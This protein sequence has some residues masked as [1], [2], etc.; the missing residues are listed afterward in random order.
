[1]SILQVNAFGGESPSVSPRSLAPGAAVTATNLLAGSNEFHPLADDRTLA[2]TLANSN[3]ATLYKQQRVTANG[4]FATEVQGWRSDAAL[5]SFVKGQID[6][7]K[8]ERTYYSYNDG[9]T[10]PRVFDTTIDK[11][12]GVTPP[13]AAPMVTHTAA[14]V[15]TIAEDTS[16]R[17]AIPLAL[18]QSAKDTIS[19]LAVGTGNTTMTAGAAN[20]WLPFGTTVSAGTLPAHVLGDYAFCALMT[21]GANGYTLSTDYSWMTATALY[22]SQITFGGYVYWAVP[23]TL[24]GIGRSVDVTALTNKIKEVENPDPGFSRT[25]ITGYTGHGSTTPQR[26]LYTDDVCSSYA[27]DVLVRYAV[28]TEPQ[29]SHIDALEAAKSAAMAALT[30]YNNLAPRIAATKGFYSLAKVTSDITNAIS[31]FAEKVVLSTQTALKADTGSWDETTFGSALKSSLVALFPSTFTVAG[32]GSNTLLN[33]F[34]IDGAISIKGDLVRASVLS[35]LTSTLTGTFAQINS[36]TVVVNAIMADMDN[37]LT[38][39]LVKAVSRDTMREKY[40][41][42]FQV[43]DDAQTRLNAV[44]LGIANIR[45]AARQVSDDYNTI[46]ASIGA[47][48]KTLFERDVAATMPDPVTP[49]YDTRFYLTTWVTSWGEESAPSAPSLI[50]EKF[51]T[52]ADSCTIPKP[53]NLVTAEGVAGWRLYRSNSGF[54]QTSF[55]LVVGKAGETGAVFDGDTFLYFDKTLASYTDNQ[56]GADLGETLPSTA[57][58]KPDTRLQGMVGMAN[59]MMAAFY[60]NVVCF[61]EPYVPYAWPIAYQMTVKYPIVGLGSFGSTLIALTRGSPYLMSG[62]DSASVSSAEIPSTQSCVSQR[63]IVSVEGGVLYAS[64]DGICLVD[65]NG[66]NVVTA[67]LFSREDWQKL[68]PSSIVAACHDGVYFFTY[69]G[70]GGGSYALDFA[71]RKLISLDL[72]GSALFVDKVNDTLYLASGTSVKAMFSG[73]GRRTATFKTGVSNV[74]RQMPFAW[75]QVFSDFSSPVTVKWYGDSALVHT[76]TVSSLTPVRLPPG[77]YLE[78]QVEISSSARVT[79]VVLCGETAELR[80]V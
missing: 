8:T 50:I 45:T 55:Q 29:K 39:E 15:Y 25:D 49:I 32:V 52:E 63:S 40:P 79:S 33:F 37:G 36:R 35:L 60:D 23:I 41:M 13:D 77:R 1:M 59:G 22:G 70:N 74:G 66:A 17:S 57:W 75:L 61:C 14:N 24:Q 69:T 76:A 5:L 73:T 6:D 18:E 72:S 64:P 30:D 4:A 27:N 11:L 9:V 46:D 26:Q 67:G 21:S 31:S 44:V 12:L 78:H 54:N 53:A 68:T 51:D 47:V 80:E 2:V 43:P 20:G 10:A 28:T 56:N 65:Q 71:S 38:S 19:G 58:L 62:S 34:D 3:P 16:A 7:D 42:E 48:I